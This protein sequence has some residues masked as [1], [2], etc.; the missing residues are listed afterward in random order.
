MSALVM[1]ISELYF[2]HV[3]GLSDVVV[4]FADDTVSKLF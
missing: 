1:Y 2:T 4:Y 3:L